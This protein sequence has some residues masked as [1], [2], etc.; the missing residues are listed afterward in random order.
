MA[1]KRYTKKKLDDPARCKACGQVVR[2]NQTIRDLEPKLVK[3]AKTDSLADVARAHKLTYF[4][5]YRWWQKRGH[6]L[7]KMDRYIIEP[8]AGTS[9]AKASKAAG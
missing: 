2:A 7:A 3:Q 9:R 4:Q 6:K 5:V 1:T 8:A